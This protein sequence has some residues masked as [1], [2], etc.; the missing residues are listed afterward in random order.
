MNYMSV[1]QNLNTR[2][3]IIW[4][5]AVT[6]AKYHC[7]PAEIITQDGITY[8]RNAIRVLSQNDI[9]KFIQL[10]IEHPEIIE[11][12]FK[13]FLNVLE[14]YEK[15][16]TRIVTKNIK[17]QTKNIIQQE[18][19][20]LYDELKKSNLCTDMFMIDKWVLFIKSQND[21]GVLFGG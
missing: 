9:N 1:T 12:A 16:E 15:N 4:E 8:H 14:E 7:K 18:M 17:K 5:Q 19:K 2:F 13:C 11:I 3:P 6:H 10:Q 20:K 21:L